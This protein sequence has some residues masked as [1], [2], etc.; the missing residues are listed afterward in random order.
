MKY[1]IPDDVQVERV[2]TDRIPFGED[3]IVLPLF[4]ITWGGGVRFPM[5]PF[6]RY[7]LEDHNLVSIQVAVNT[8]RILC[9]AIRLAETNNLSFTLGDLMLMYMVSRNPKYDKYY[10]TTHCSALNKGLL[11]TGRWPNLIA[12]LR[13]TNQDAPT[14]LDYELTYVGFAHRKD[15]NRMKE[16]RKSIPSGQSK[17]QKQP[18]AP[19]EKTHYGRRRETDSAAEDEDQKA[20]KKAKAAEDME[21]LPSDLAEGD[22]A[23]P[24]EPSV[25]F[26]PNFECSDGHVITI[27]DSLE[28][29]P[30]LAMTFLKGLALPKDV[31]NLPTG[32]AAN[33]AELC[34]LLAKAVQ[35][36]S[37]AFGDMDVF[38]E[39]KRSLR[40]DLRAKSKEVDQ[41]ADQV[42]ALEVKVAEAESVRQE[43]DRLLL[44]IKD[45]EE[46]NGQL[47]KEKQQM[48]EDL[49]KK[50]EDAGD[51][52][53]ATTRPVG[54]DY[55]EVPEA[56]HRREPPVVPPLELP[57]ALL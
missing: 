26:V 33:V 38:L 25:P 17:Q 57:E 19:T 18:R 3:F 24:S 23:N 8:W 5:S 21:V 50:L 36:V 22:P 30:L 40:V 46:E 53:V 16:Q 9:S 43:R 10:L 37:K 14:L 6:L 35:C 4:A 34:L 28:E 54:L 2:T 29:S 49:P 41:F 15:K 20:K 7:F 11:I 55:A 47:K 42:E 44:Q 56:D 27:D 13:C 52:V 32:K 1:S 39:T 51:V 12:L 45:A 48:E 31:E